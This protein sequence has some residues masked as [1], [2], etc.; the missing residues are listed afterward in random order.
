MFDFLY[1]QSLARAVHKVWV[2][3]DL[4][5][6][7][8]EN[9]RR[10]LDA[11]I[12]DFELLGRPAEQIWYLGDAIE[13]ADPD[14]LRAMCTLQENA[15]AALNLPLCYATGN[16]D[17]DYARTHRDEA[18]W[19]P[20]YQMVHDHPGWKT[21]ET[22]ED[23]YFRTTVGK[24]PVYFLCDHVSRENRWAVTHSHVVWGQEEYPYTQADAESLRQKMAAE[25]E[26]II[27][28]GHYGFSGCNRDHFL[29]DHLLPLPKTERI[30]FYGHSH[31]G[32]WVWGK[33]DTWRRIC[34]VDWHDVPQIDVSSFENIRGEHCRSVLLHI[35]EDG[36]M[37]IFFRDHDHHRFTEV[38]FPAGENGPEGWNDMRP[39]Y[40]IKR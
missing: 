8:P 23:F 33:Q 2:L 39:K 21:T 27:T 35:Y 9:T 13:G 12:S 17:Y 19:M 18:P 38:Y 28:C 29:M 5:Q 7:L 26:P 37:G 24:Y 1:Q 6:A 31:I 4:Q 25:T 16:H 15:F 14:R 36:N 34:W 22:C 11:G 32:D 30:H 20:F 40:E 3:S 10:C